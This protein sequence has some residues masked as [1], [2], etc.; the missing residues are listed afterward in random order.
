MD[1]DTKS[2]WLAFF[3]ILGAMVLSACSEP[4]A[5]RSIDTNLRVVRIDGCQ[6]LESGNTPNAQN[7]VLTHKG[8]C[9]NPQHKTP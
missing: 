8:N 9:D 5:N 1:S 6:Y 3:L 2:V 4:P 7:Y